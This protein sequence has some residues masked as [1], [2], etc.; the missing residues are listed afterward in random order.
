MLTAILILRFNDTA[1]KIFHYNAYL[2]ITRLIKIVPH[3]NT[4][5]DKEKHSYVRVTL[6]SVLLCLFP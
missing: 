5:T 4:H 2:L 6:Q 1:T 3:M